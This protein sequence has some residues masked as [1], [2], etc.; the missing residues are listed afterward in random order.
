MIEKIYIFLCYFFVVSVAEKCTT[1]LYNGR[2][3]HKY[4]GVYFPFSIGGKLYFYR[5][6]RDKS[7][8]IQ[9][10]LPGGKVGEETDYGELRQFYDV[11]FPYSVGGK[12][13]FLDTEIT[14]MIG[15]FE[16]YY[17]VERWVV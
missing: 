1:D 3:I 13:Y 14:Q 17:Q 10:L 4:Y 12:Q 5:E 11:Q 6:E 15:L 8:I 9:E 7:F 16:N 2:D